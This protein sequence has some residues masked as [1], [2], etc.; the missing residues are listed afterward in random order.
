M[1]QTKL[2]SCTCKSAFQDARYGLGKRVVNV[3]AKGGS[4]TCCGKA[5]LLGGDDVRSVVA[6]AKKPAKKKG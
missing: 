4:C 6:S 1:G 3:N 2:V 5:V